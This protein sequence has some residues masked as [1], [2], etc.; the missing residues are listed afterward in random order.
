MA[1]LAASRLPALRKQH[2]LVE[3]AGLKQACPAGVFVSLTPDDPSMW[4]GVLFVRDGPYSPAVLRFQILFPISYPRTPPLITF[5][6]DMF[7]PLIAPLSTHVY[8]A[9]FRE[10]GTMS[11]ADHERLSPGGFSLKQA[12]PD[13]YARKSKASTPR[14]DQAQTPPRPPPKDGLPAGLT[15]RSVSTALSNP[16]E[17]AIPTGRSISMYEVLR[18]MRSAFDDESV[19]DAV[20]L[21]NSGN[22]GAWHAWRTHRMDNGHVYNGEE[23]ATAVVDVRESP[24]PSTT[25][26]ESAVRH[27]DWNWQGVWEERVQRG[28]SASLTESALFGGSSTG[29]DV[30]RFLNMEENDVETAKDNIRR[31][32]GQ[33]I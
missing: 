20:Q 1:H 18:Y 10:N 13:W 6:T 8:S 5:T 31:T 22:P 12:F 27:G 16:Q 15:P 23:A 14:P 32:L 19:L 11:S 4:T 7:H 9:D 24:G 3:F 29:D 17:S 2:L 21:P 33:T 26:S 30:I 25:P 28:I